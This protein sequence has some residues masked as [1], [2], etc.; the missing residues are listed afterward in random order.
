M[1]AEIE[2]EREGC[3]GSESGSGRTGERERGK[4]REAVMGCD[5]WT[6]DYWITV[7]EGTERTLVVWLGNSYTPCFMVIVPYFQ[8]CIY[9][10][11]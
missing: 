8:T 4:E 7:G 2:R 3:R 11:I 1:R 10:Y 6:C 5:L 9:F